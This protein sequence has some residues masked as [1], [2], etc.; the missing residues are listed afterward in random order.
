MEAADSPNSGIPRISLSWTNLRRIVV[1]L[2][3]DSR[4]TTSD[5]HIHNAP[6]C[7]I[8]EWYIWNRIFLSV[9]LEGMSLIY[10]D[11]GN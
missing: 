8:V 4:V 2:N 6:E 11:H 9:L 10:R 1:L 7:I 5:V 3:I